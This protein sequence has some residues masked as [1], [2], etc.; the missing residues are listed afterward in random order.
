VDAT[1]RLLP[2]YE[3]STKG[4][5][6]L[7]SGYDTALRYKILNRL[8]KLEEAIQKPTLVFEVPSPREIACVILLLEDECFYRLNY[9]PLFRGKKKKGRIL[10]NK[11]IIL[12]FKVI[13]TR[14]RLKIH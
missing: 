13:S 2:V 7:A 1:G 12:N 8:E 3:L 10:E 9:I 11:R 6:L 14:Q 4:A 5:L